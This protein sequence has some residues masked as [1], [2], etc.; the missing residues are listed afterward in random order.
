MFFD[1]FPL[2]GQVERYNNGRLEALQT[3]SFN[4]KSMD[5]R[6]YNTDHQLVTVTLA[7]TLLN[8][9]VAIGEIS[10]KVV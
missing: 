8:R 10:L 6:G 1:S 3:P 4:Y 5:S 9:L 7:K 2:R